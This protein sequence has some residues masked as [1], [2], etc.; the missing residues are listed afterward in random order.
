EPYIRFYQRLVALDRAGAVEI[1][2]TALKQQPRAEVFDRILIPTLV[3]AE[4]D[5]ARDELDDREEAFVW[6]VVGEVVDS[7]EGTPE[8][9]LEALTSSPGTERG[10]PP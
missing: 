8:L 4:R 2:E 6:Q 1:V 5:A 10:P 9:G 7:L 3:L